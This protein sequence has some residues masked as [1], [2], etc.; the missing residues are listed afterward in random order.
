MIQGS[1]KG[2]LEIYA[3][4][5]GKPLGS[6]DLGTAVIAAPMTYTVNGQQFIAVLAGYGGGP[7]YDPFPTDS[8]AYRYSNAGRLIVLKLGGTAVPQPPRVTDAP[9]PSLP[10]RPHDPEQIARGGLLYNRY[11][12]RCHV[13]GRGVLPDLRRMTPST[14]ELFDDIVLR[15]IYGP[16]GMARWDDV[17]THEDA[18]AIHAFIVEQ[19][20]EGKSVESAH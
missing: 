13:F 15:G 5:T 11:C 19:A 18:E 2:S 8:A 3:A 10:Q 1:I 17:L 12:G 7:M 9:W 16:Q 6:I 14:H 4:D 20:W